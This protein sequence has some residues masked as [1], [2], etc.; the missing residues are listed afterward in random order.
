MLASVARKPFEFSNAVRGEA[1]RKNSQEICRGASVLENREDFGND[2]DT[3]RIIYTVKLAQTIYV[4][5][6][7]H[8]K[9]KTAIAI[10]P[11]DLELIDSRP[12]NV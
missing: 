7:F 2:K 12:N 8:K 3:Y 1:P 9:S 5:H 6:A 11:T 4:L 10:S